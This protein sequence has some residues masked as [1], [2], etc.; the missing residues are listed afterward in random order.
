MVQP[1]GDAPQS[2]E[3]VA[4]R[5][6]IRTRDVTIFESELDGRTGIKP[7]L[8]RT[9]WDGTHFAADDWALFL[10]VESSDDS[11]PCPDTLVHFRLRGVTVRYTVDSSWLFRMIDIMFGDS[12]D[13]DHSESRSC[14]AIRK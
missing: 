10:S 4:K 9:K 11:V 5:L 7:V 14:S 2:C 6:K 8:Y 1:G 13:T 12:V 3:S